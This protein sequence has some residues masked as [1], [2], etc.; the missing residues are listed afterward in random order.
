MKNQKQKIKIFLANWQDEKEAA[1]LYSQ[2]A[3]QEKDSK[4]KK[5]YRKLAEIEQEHAGIWKDELEKLGVKPRFKPKAKAKLLSFLGRVLG[6]NALLDVLEKSE[7]SAIKRYT[8]QI[9]KLNDPELTKE[10]TGIIP[11]EKG[12]SKILTELAGKKVPVSGEKWHKGG[13]SIRDIIFGMN[14]GLLS[15]FSLIAGVAG[16]AVSNS[17]VLLAGLAGAVAGAISMAAGALVSVKAEK[18]VLQKHIEMEKTELKTMPEA[19]E[20][21]LALMYE[22]KGLTPK[23]AKR[24]AKKIMSNHD[25]ALATMAR[26]EL[27]INPEELGSP[28]KAAFCSGVSFVIGAALPVLPFVFMGSLAFRT[29]IILSLSGFFL[30]GAGRTVAT[31]RNPLR[32]GLE[33]FFIGTAAAIIT[34]F[35]G[36]LIGGGV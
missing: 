26:E 16:A 6:H 22:L 29:A 31:G 27:G 1:M 21:E 11:D 8:G 15:T 36:S 20:E 3:K 13:E 2:M 12:H 24:V 18:E 23:S 19:E 17:I 5:I 33:M 4:K 14:D 7:G 34:Y 28:Y 35:I 30:I 25:I 10:L 9:K 32:S